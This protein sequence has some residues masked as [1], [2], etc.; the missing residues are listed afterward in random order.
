MLATLVLVQHFSSYDYGGWAVFVFFILSGYWVSRMYIGKYR[1][2]RTPWLSFVLNR[3]FRLL[4]V[5]IACLVFAYAAFSSAQVL[6]DFARNGGWWLRTLPIVG[7]IENKVLIGPFWSLDI[8]FQF[9]LIAPLLVVLMHRLS[10]GRAIAATAVVALTTVYFCFAG[11]T[12]INRSNL[13]LVLY[14]LGFFLGG[15]VIHRLEYVASRRAAFLSLAVLIATPAVLTAYQG[16]KGIFV[17][18][19]DARLM[20]LNP[21]ISAIGA[22]VALP[23]ISRIVA[24][25]SSSLDLHFGNFSYA[26]YAFHIVPATIYY[27]H[28]GHLPASMRLPQLAVAL[29]AA[30]VGSL[31]VYLC[32]DRPFEILRRRTAEPARHK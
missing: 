8:E 12:D 7:S 20:A 6:P 15:I 23:L 22:F 3:Y 21:G 28:Y 10:P 27:A 30:L 1:R 5:Y 24:K 17:A 2:G 18:L 31:V 11:W 32:V 16:T 19:L 4:P 13:K 9:Y 25:K 29:G 26:L 14:F